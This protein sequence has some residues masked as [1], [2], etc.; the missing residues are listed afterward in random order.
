MSIL[1]LARFLV[2]FVTTAA[3]SQNNFTYS[4]A[5]PKAGDV[6]TFTYEPSGD[7]ANT[8]SPVEVV[9][10]QL[11]TKGMKAI[12]IALTKANG[13]YTGSVQTDDS[14]NFIFLGI[15]SNNKFDNNF[16]NG[17][18]IHLYDGDKIKKESYASEARFHQGYA[19][20]VDVE[21][22]A[23][24]T[25]SSFEKEFELYPENRT[26]YIVT[27]TRAL[28]AA[29]KP[30]A[31]VLIQK[32]IENFLKN[33]LKEEADYNTL[34]TE[35]RIVAK[36]PQQAKLI[37]NIKKE[38]FP[39]GEWTL[40]K[41][42]DEFYDMTD[43]VKKEA[44]LTE[45]ISKTETD[46]MWVNQRTNITDYKLE[47]AAAYSKTKD[48]D[49]F[50][51]MIASADIKDKTLLASV[52]NNLAW[53]MQQDSTNLPY[54]EEI[55]KF[56]VET[57]KAEWQ[58]PTLPKPDAMTAKQ[59]ERNRKTMYSMYADTY[60][61]VLYRTGNYKKGLAYSKDAAI[62]IGEG[63]SADDNNTYALLAEKALPSKEYKKQLEQFVKDG[64]YT[65]AVTDILKRAYVK[66]K[67]SDTG[68]DDYMATLQKE[69]QLKMIEEL[70]KSMMNE[71]APSFALYN[72]DGNKINISDLKGKV[73]V[74]DFWATWCGPCKAS[75]PG[76]QKM[77]TKY[78]DDPTV[79]F[80]F[81]D[82]WEQVE[83]KK[84]NAADF[85]AGK[86]YSFDVLLDPDNKVV[87][88][89]KVDGI[90]TKFVIDKDGKIRFK[91]IGF[92]GSDDKLVQELTAMIEMAGNPD[93]KAF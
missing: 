66:E 37:D 78:K 38:K 14:G 22:S 80:V 40:N 31:S 6:I 74:V 67:K 5:K 71:T 33:G 59:W 12:D 56:A 11:Q 47:V 13:K 52:Y 93:K 83:D 58:K 62:V 69:S 54:A 18:F 87:E 2:V 73:V 55:S 91:A 34:E 3:C 41:K 17:Y 90:P 32:E 46:P 70:H 86:K 30:D 8:L 65:P 68:F 7:I 20:N 29:Q 15:T 81:V 60:G 48:W 84:Q 57:A 72:L 4:P 64:K 16:N 45:I 63:K 42:V 35:Y 76:M 21:R 19:T 25:V 88:Q 39:N 24:K 44:L 23:D 1:K 49:Q 75:F 92:D 77:V 61:M 28:V 53:S 51:R 79:K 36:L 10:Y 50:K 89:F 27:Y 82:T 85:I 43:P 26:K 9:A